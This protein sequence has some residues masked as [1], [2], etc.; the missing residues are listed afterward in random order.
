M[1]PGM[2]DLLSALAYLLSAV[3]VYGCAFAC[4]LACACVYAYIFMLLSL[5]LSIVAL[6]QFCTRIRCFGLDHLN[7]TCS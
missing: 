3:Y 4:A 6:K 7:G 5:C 1:L 2:S